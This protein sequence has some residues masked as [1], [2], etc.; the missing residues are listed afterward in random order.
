MTAMPK[1]REDVAQPGTAHVRWTRLS[2][3]LPSLLVVGGVA[4]VVTL[5]SVPVG[6]GMATDCLFTGYRGCHEVGHAVIGNAVPEGLVFLAA[7]IVAAS[8]EGRHYR[9]FIAPI[10]VVFSI[11]VFVVMMLLAHSYP[12]RGH[13]STLRHGRRA[14]PARD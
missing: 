13:P 9:R 5:L 2:T 6:F 11:A 12:P 3:A 4:L 7:V 10:G 1:R 8:E 14:E